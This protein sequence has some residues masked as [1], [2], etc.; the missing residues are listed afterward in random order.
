VDCNLLHPDLA[1]L[2]SDS[3][4]SIGS[5]D[6]HYVRI[7]HHPSTVISNIRAVFSPSS[8]IDEAELLY[9]LLVE[10]ERMRQQERLDNGCESVDDGTVV[11]AGNGDAFHR[12]IDIR[13]SVGVHPYNTDD[14]GYGNKGIFQNDDSTD[15]QNTTPSRIDRILQLDRSTHDPATGDDTLPT[16]PFIT[17]IGE[18]GLDYS[19]GFPTMER[20]IPWFQFQL[21]LAKDHGLPLFLHERLAF[22]D[23]VDAI[24]GVF[25]PSSSST[26]SPIPSPPIVIHCFTGSIP[27]CKEYIARG[28]YI[29]LSGFI[30]KKG[31]GPAAIRECLRTG[32]LP[33][34]RLMVET[35]AP[36]MGFTACRASYYKAAEEEEADDDFCGREFRELSGK[37]KKKLVKGIYPNVP[38]ALPLVLKCVMECI[39]EGRIERGEVEMELEVVACVLFENSVRFFGFCV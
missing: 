13:M 26:S 7:L 23:L 37:K 5:I 11:E 30:L 3:S 8:T 32:I 12:H 39:N 6:P 21:T 24:D 2:L 14:D 17:C 29:S 33:L 1:S 10:R 35:D 22:R 28:Y 25:P 18:T 15:N 38:S 16:T 4:S 34:D 9:P 27:E 20:Q 36:Y 31:D 19:E